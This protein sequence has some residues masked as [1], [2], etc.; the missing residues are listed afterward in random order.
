MLGGKHLLSL[1]FGAVEPDV[2][3]RRNLFLALR[4]VLSALAIYNAGAAL[5]RSMSNSRVSMMTSIA[6]NLVNIS[7][8]ISDLCVQY[9]RCR[10]QSLPLWS[11]RILGA[12]VMMVLLRNRHNLIFIGHLFP[13]SL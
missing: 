13:L 12:V 8:I 6:M 1:I 5:F 7:G 11:P 3:Q 4:A 2:M 9:G 10:A